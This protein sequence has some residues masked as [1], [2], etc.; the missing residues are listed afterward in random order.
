MKKIKIRLL[1]NTMKK[2][3]IRLKNE[4]KIIIK[5]TNKIYNNKLYV[6]VEVNFNI[7]KN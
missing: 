3:K 6:I 5:K 7:W 1:N 2:I 4:I